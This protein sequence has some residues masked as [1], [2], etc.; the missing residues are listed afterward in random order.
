[1]ISSFHILAIL[2][3]LG[4]SE[5]KEEKSLDIFFIDV[6]GGAAT[7]L[8]TPERES[9]L[10]D[11]GWA[12][13]EDRD[14]K[15]IAHVLKDVAG[16]DHLDHL[17]TTHWHMDH[18]GGV[19]GLA[20]RVRI[21]HFWDR[22]IPDPNVPGG[23]KKNYPDGPTTVHPIGVA[24]H[25]ASAG[26]RGIL[27]AGQ[28]LPLR[29]SIKTVVL[30]S[31]G[32]TIK[33]KSTET[34]PRNPLC[35]DCPA[36]LPVD[37]SDNVRSLAFKFTLGRFDFLDCGDL[38]WNIEK[39]LVCPHDMI[40]QIDLYQVTHHGMDISNHPVLVK[41]IAPTVAIMNNG[42]RKGG[43]PK[44]VK[45]LKSI[46]SI[47]AFYALHKNL[48]TGAGRER[49]PEVDRQPQ[50]RRRPLHPRSGF[51]RRFKLHRPHQRRRGLQDVFVEMNSTGASN[52]VISRVIA[53]VRR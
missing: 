48:A 44:T 27:H 33:P 15:R 34:P 10:I 31:G 38:T 7:L 2:L 49:G 11:S 8:I 26:K 24:Y 1:M 41:T 17:V 12:G 51:R 37:P 19:A 50:R 45:L 16:C 9:I 35:D 18:Y 52:L 14:P 3:T 36:D 53:R 20:K 6:D 42:S 13:R 22:G 40:G 21:D 25:E 43:S 29:G 47:Q 46:G 23:D 32:E 4:L 5:S 30:A 39:N 28:T